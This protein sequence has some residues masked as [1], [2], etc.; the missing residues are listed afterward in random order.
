MVTT[1]E[2]TGEGTFRAAIDSA[3]NHFGPDTIRF[4]IPDISGTENGVIA[5]QSP[6]PKITDD[7]LVI[8]GTAQ[9]L[10]Y[11][12]EETYLPDIQITG[13]GIVNKA[14]PALQI[15]ANNVHINYLFFIGFPGG[16]IY[17]QDMET[18]SVSGC[19]LGTE[20]EVDPDKRENEQ[21]NG[22]TIRGSTHILIGPSEGAPF[23]NL[24]SGFNGQGIWISD[25]SAFN[26]VIGNEIGFNTK[27]SQ[28]FRSGNTMNGISIT[29]DCYLNEIIGNRIGQS[30]EHGIMIS[31]AGEN[32]LIDNRIGTVSEFQEN[33]ANN[34]SGIYL[35]DGAQL[36]QVIGNQIGYNGGYGIVN[37]GSSTTRNL[38]SQNLL[39]QN[40]SGGIYNTDGGNMNLTPPVLE[41]LIDNQLQGKAGTHQTIELFLDYENQGRFFLDTLIADNVGNFAGEIAMTS[42]SLNITAT[43]RDEF[44]NTSAFSLPLKVNSPEVRHE[45]IV[46]NTTENGPGSFRAAIDSAN[47]KIGP[48]TI[49]F[50][51]PKTDPGFDLAK[52]VWVIKPNTPLSVILDDGLFIDGPS[53][54][55]FLGEDLNP[56][57]PEIVISGLEESSFGAGLTVLGM[58]TEIYG[59]TINNFNGAGISLYKS[60][61]ANISGCYIGT[62]YDGMESAGNNDGI[63]LG[64][65][66]TNSVVGPTEYYP[67]GNLI[68]GNKRIGLLLVDSARHNIIAGNQIGTNRD[69]SD[70]IGNKNEG[71]ALTRS[72]HFNEIFDNTIMGNYHGVA[73][74]ESQHNIIAHNSI[75]F[76]NNES[77]YGNK[78]SG[79]LLWMNS[80]QNLI[81]DNQIG[82]NEDYG[83]YNEGLGTVKNIFSR[84][85]FQNNGY[86]DI[87]NLNGANLEL[88]PPTDLILNN[89]T[90]AGQAG[91]NQTIELFLHEDTTGIHFLDSLLTNTSGDFFYIFDTVP[92]QAS[93][94]ATARD[95]AGNTSEFSES[96]ALTT[97][98]NDRNSSNTYLYQ[99]HP[100]PTSHETNITFQIDQPS[101]INIS[102]FDSNGTI[103]KEILKAYPSPGQYT[104]AINVADLPQGVYYYR[105]TL[106]Y[107][108]QMTRKL[109]VIH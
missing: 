32:F 58:Y 77:V 38:L 89:N 46:T 90:L 30:G 80:S 13:F 33:V 73:L 74:F 41:S 18:G 78:G 107:G 65:L 10:I 85:S 15:G 34:G 69:N 35:E 4:N 60:G 24:I 47:L 88:N 56:F 36:N 103:T 39:S 102:L 21:G 63:V 98:T 2:D 28:Y 92:Y 79:I 70:T 7:G 45:L 105:L 16:G 12:D 37:A 72:C 81:I 83:I 59:I 8:L 66:T 54:A 82:F 43:A 86:G 29:N 48:D 22:I 67:Y 57:G 1:N 27:E 20:I 51:I 55:S 91:P 64:Y 68:S 101:T 108:S 25:S 14:A 5:L 53:Q 99:N 75:G 96:Y 44:G 95:I 76:L 31:N 3:N 62:N 109:V 6:L 11:N 71:L 100:N 52:G 93:I 49:R 42:D 9:I 40:V 106:P 50:N 26:V 17:F 94:L 87:V 84:N 104:L 23:G 61:F 97:A 19:Y